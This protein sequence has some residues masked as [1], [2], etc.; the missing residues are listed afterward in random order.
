[1]DI[2]CNKVFQDACKPMP[3]NDDINGPM[4]NCKDI[5]Q[6]AKNLNMPKHESHQTVGTYVFA[7]AC[8]WS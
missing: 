3:V 8:R 5:A 7:I 1:M 6:Y 2:F 4:Q